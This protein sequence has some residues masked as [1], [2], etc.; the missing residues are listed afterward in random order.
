VEA[1]VGAGHRVVVESSAG[2]GS[3]F[4]DAEYAAAG[5]RLDPD[6]ARVWAADLVVKVKEP[7][8]SEYELLRPGLVLFTFLHLA[9]EPELT[10]QLIASGVTAIA[11]ETV[12][13]A[14]GSLPIL[15]PMSEVAGRMAPQVAAHELTHMQGGAGKLLGGVPGTPPARVVVLGAGTVGSNAARIAL[16]MGA[17]VVLFN[18][19]IE[20]LRRLEMTLGGRLVTM[21][22]SAPTIGRAVESADVVIGAALVPGDRAPV[23]VT[24]PMVEAMRP[25]SVIVDV[26][27]DQGGCIATTRPTS[28]TDPTYILHGVV[29]YAVPNMPGAVPHTSTLALNN[30]TLPYVLLLADQGFA[31]A[32]R[33]SEALAAGVNVHAGAVTHPAVANALGLEL[34]PRR[35]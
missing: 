30:V 21:A 24:E 22:A 6:P 3:G 34:V 33:T 18:R 13:L 31:A 16:G 25:G 27:V 15:A 1:L 7:L 12:A 14:D 11:Y 28:H 35:I 5:A 4:A 9:A 23:L 17:E 32:C 8:G 29:H 26:A 20:P 2:A 10:Q 19:S